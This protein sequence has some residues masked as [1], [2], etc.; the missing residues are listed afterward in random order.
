MEMIHC[1]LC[2][3]LSKYLLCDILHSDS[4][5]ESYLFQLFKLYDSIE[6]IGCW[7]TE[8]EAKKPAIRLGNNICKW[9]EQARKRNGSRMFTLSKE[10]IGTC[11]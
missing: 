7:K 9:I 1:F 2:Y 4:L 10:E 8:V 6:H 3:E 5:S 11:S